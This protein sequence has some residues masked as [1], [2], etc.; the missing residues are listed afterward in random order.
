MALTRDIGKTLQ[1]LEDLVVINCSTADQVYKST[2]RV[3]ASTLAGAGVNGRVFDRLGD[4]LGTRYRT[5]EPF[6]YL[7]ASR[8][9]TELDRKLIL[10]VKLQHGDSSSAGDMTNLTTDADP[11]NRTFFSSALTTPMGAWTTGPFYG[12]SLPAF[13]DLTTAK[14]FLRT[15]TTFQHSTQ[16]QTT[17]SSGYDSL[18]IG[19]AVRFGGA[20]ELP[21]KANS[22]GIG[23]TSTSTST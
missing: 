11:G 10:G 15:V 13:W 17:E 8:T 16:S 20:D 12:Q 6:A 1:S 9:S 18:H 22:T 7:W 4:E 23:S 14:R 19:A 2:V 5:A 21:D 3:I